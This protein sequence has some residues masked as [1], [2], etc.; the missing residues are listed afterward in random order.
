MQDWTINATTDEITFYLPP[1]SGTDNIE[2]RE[3]PS[4]GVGGSDVWALGAWSPHYGYPREV[5]FYGD[6]LWFA[7]SP[8]A[9]QTFWASCIGDYS[10]FGR[11]SPIV[12]SDAVTFAINAQIGRASCREREAL[13]DV[14][15]A[16]RKK[17]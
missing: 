8:S 3:M 6:R 14:S 10:N 2:V 15:V 1:A 7:S 5:E 4:S 13:A 9:P 16:M 17:I 11:S 12:D